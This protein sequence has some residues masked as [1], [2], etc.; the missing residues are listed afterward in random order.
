M[1]SVTLFFEHSNKVEENF[2]ILL[3][4]VY[5]TG[6]LPIVPGKII[7]KLSEGENGLKISCYF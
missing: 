7:A 2:T 5:Y 4:C 6:N 3:L 1:S